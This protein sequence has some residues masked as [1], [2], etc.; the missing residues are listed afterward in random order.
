MDTDANG[1]CILD[2]TPQSLG[3]IKNELKKY[4]VILQNIW[5]YREAFSAYTA[6]I[7][8]ADKFSA[9]SELDSS[10]TFRSIFGSLNLYYG[11]S[12]DLKVKDYNYY[13]MTSC[14]AVCEIAF[15]PGVIT[16]RLVSHEL[17]HAFDE[18][19]G[20]LATTLLDQGVYDTHGSDDKN[21]WTFIT[22][23][24]T[25]GTTHYNRNGGMKSP[26]NG[27]QCDTVPCQYHYLVAG[28]KEMDSDSYTSGEEFADLFLNWSMGG[29]VNNYRGNFLNHWMTTNMVDWVSSSIQ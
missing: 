16:S 29:F 14:S 28:G 7:V 4:G 23:D 1:T 5:Y 12:P 27:Y 21:S 19:T 26:D 8:T 6:I 3:G 15:L 9:Y 18:M 24:D 13:G 22:G 11:N 17:G 10:S 20:R 2:P 25:W